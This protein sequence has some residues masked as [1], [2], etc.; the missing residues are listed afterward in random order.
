ME[1]FDQ[2]NQIKKEYKE[3]GR[4]FHFYTPSELCLTLPLIEKISLF[5]IGF[6]GLRVLSLIV[7]Y[8]FKFIE[9]DAAL[10]SSLINLICYLL[11]AAVFV[12]I[13]IFDRNHSIKKVFVDF[14][15]PH[16]YIYGLIGFGLIIGIE[17]LISNIYSIAIPSYG[18]NINQSEISSMT[19]NYPFI[20][21]FMTVIL[22]PFCEELTYRVGIID[23][24]GNNPKY[25]TLGLILSSIL[26]GFIHSNILT[27]IL[28]IGNP[29]SPYPADILSDMILNEWLNLPIYIISGLILSL[30]YTRS[31]KISASLFAHMANNLYSFIM[32]FIAVAIRKA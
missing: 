19:I 23:S 9:I 7:V 14:K 25:R 31:G 27:L 17:L 1:Y 11:I 20:L 2:E 5:L 4:K 16:T 29:A 32:I 22:A 13:L 26:F 10:K 15:H 12:T 8:I 3:E 21:F 28:Y 30:V 18:S 24:F 6:I